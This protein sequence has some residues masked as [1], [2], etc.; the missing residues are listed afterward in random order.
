MKKLRILYPVILNLIFSFLFTI[1]ILKSSYS[2]EIQIS[3]IGNKY[4]DENAIL[5]IIDKKPENISENYSNY[6]L[7]TLD[8]SKLFEN[9]IIKI[10][11]QGYIINIK[12]YPNINNIFFENNDR[13]KDEE[14]F[15]IV[16]SLNINNLNPNLINEFIIETTK[17][18]E[19][20][21]YNNIDI[22]YNKKIDNSSNSADLIFDI[23]EGDITKINKI[24]FDG[25][26]SIDNIVLK[27]IIRS[28]TKSLKNIFANN[29]FKKYLIQN[30]LQIISEYYINKGFRDIKIDFNI[31]YLKSNKVNIYYQINEGK[32][33]FFNK[34]EILDKNNIINTKLENDL[35]ILIEDSIKS[36]QDF[37]ISKIEDT[38][39]KIANLIIDSGIKFFEIKPLQKLSDNKV[40]IIFQII[41]I[42]PIYTNK[43]NIY[44]NTRT[45]DYVVRR[46]LE[47]SEGDPIYISQ[48]NRIEKKLRS[49]RLFEKVTIQKQ[50]VGEN[51][52]D[53]NINVDEKQTGSVNAGLAIG[54]I[55]GFAVVAGLSERNFGGT[56]RSIKALVNTSSD[57]NQFTLETEDRLIYEDN[58]NYKVSTNYIEED[59]SKTSSY[60]LNTFN[61]GSGISYDI[62]KNLR[63]NIDLNYLIKD[64]I[65][66]DSSKVSNTIGS[67]SGENVSFLLKNNLFYSTLNSLIIPKNGR[68]IALSNLIETPTS[69][70]NG[71]IKNMITIK[72]YK[73]I[74]KNIFSNQTRVGNITSLGNNDILTDDKFSLGGRWLRGFD[75]SGAGP[76]NSRTSYIGGENLFVTKFDFSRE[77]FDNSDFP[78]Y[79]N[80]FNDYG[81]VWQNKTEPTQSD[82]KFRASYGFGIKYYSPIGP[83]G[84]TWGFPLSDESYDIKRMFLFS[85]GNID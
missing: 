50:E 62:N 54:T 35:I 47:L 46:E 80:F 20:F 18:Y 65:I 48:I 76:R 33:Y 71:Y 8:K 60:K 75:V 61:I 36:N 4:T 58:V 12:E 77:I 42:E 3:I 79:L 64:Y 41:N 16:N 34:I 59:F 31:E 38:K 83:I 39:D 11:E 13:L 84:L 63:H 44:G 27:S 30:D 81:I 23:N 68:S 78:I 28:K 57:K 15:E 5:S 32:K 82:E 70:S 22:S 17:I 74:N 37:S 6:L 53:I 43:I 55:E 24:I 7:K 14:L 2:N 29:N 72:N 51:L 19:S 69:S 52:Y 9:V 21:G 56:G 67:S 85:V 25:N 40:D 73:Q 49:L 45:F 66:T 10:T 26:T 1:I